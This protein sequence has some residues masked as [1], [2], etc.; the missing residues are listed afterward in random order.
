MNETNNSKLVPA[1][2]LGIV[3]AFVAFFLLYAGDNRT[4]TEKAGDAIGELQN[5]PG[6]AME[7]L[8]DRTPAQKLGDAIEDETDDL[9]ESLDRQPEP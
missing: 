5:G 8:E 3:I 9:R 6:E 2:L 1:I 7:Q 4:A